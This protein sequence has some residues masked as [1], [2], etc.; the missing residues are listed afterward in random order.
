VPDIY[1]IPGRTDV[2]LAGKNGEAVKQAISGVKLIP[3][4]WNEVMQKKAGWTERW[5]TEVIGNTGKQTDVV[6]PK[7]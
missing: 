3:V 5:K 4:D 6:K 7:S 1:G 2:P